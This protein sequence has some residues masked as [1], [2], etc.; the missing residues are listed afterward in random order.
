MAQRNF[1]NIPSMTSHLHSTTQKLK[2]VS[3]CDKN[4][5]FGVFDGHG[6]NGHNV[7]D[8]VKKHLPYNLAEAYAKP[9]NVIYGTQ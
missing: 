7:S 2:G 1:L 6:Q 8:Y 3:S 9:E 4:W 5:I